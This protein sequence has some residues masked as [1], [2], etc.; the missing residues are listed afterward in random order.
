MQQEPEDA[1]LKVCYS[2]FRG[3]KAKKA[4][5]IYDYYFSCELTTMS[6]KQELL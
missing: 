2:E 3:H 1:L 4:I 6:H 5:Q